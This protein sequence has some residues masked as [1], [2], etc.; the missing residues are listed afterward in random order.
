[1]LRIDLSEPEPL[2][3]LGEFEIRGELGHGGMGVVY[4]AWQP[5]LN[6]EVALKVLFEGQDRRRFLREAEMAARL[7]H[8]NIV[9]IHDRGEADGRAFIAM[10]LVE[11]GSLADHIKTQKRPAIESARILRD[12][13]RAVAYAH[14]RGVI[15]RDLKPANVLVSTD[16]TP[17]IA[18]FGLARLADD[19]SRVTKPG[20]VAG[21]PAYMPPEQARGEPPTTAVDIYSLGAVLYELLAGRPP[22]EGNVTEV[23]RQVADV[24]PS[25]L[26]GPRDLTLIAMKCLEKKPEKRYLSASDLADDLDLWLR[27]EPIT[28]RPVAS[29][30]RV[31]K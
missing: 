17:K 7:Q 14:Q 27:G 5:S 6:R 2:R 20:D 15:H 9:A 10:E 19:D 11:G 3:Q 8:S 13:A 12:L 21:S 23:L 18:D 28:A 4:R 1:M 25:P 24:E 31:V 29:W 26:A 16:G 22:F 30:E